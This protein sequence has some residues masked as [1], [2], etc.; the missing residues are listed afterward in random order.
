MDSTRAHSTTTQILRV[1]CSAI[2]SNRI[3][4]R[5]Q[6]SAIVS[7]VMTVTVTAFDSISSISISTDIR[8]EFRTGHATRNNTALCCT[9]RVASRRVLSSAFL[10]VIIYHR[11]CSVQYSKYC[12]CVCVSS[13]SPPL[14][15]LNSLFVFQVF[16][17]R[18]LGDW[19]LVACRVPRRVASRPLFWSLIA[20]K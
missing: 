8:H 17:A 13:L 20:R 4:S 1:E 15:L 6:L 10:S 14:S 19:R 7:R 16:C 9:V 11:K 2:E 18:I 12:V 3:E 5:Y